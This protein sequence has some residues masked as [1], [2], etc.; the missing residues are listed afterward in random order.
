VAHAPNVEIG[1]GPRYLVHTPVFDGPFDLLL[2]LI[3]KEQVD[4]YEVS[5]SG[6]VD[7][8]LGELEH[9]GRM[10][11][12][13]AT[14]FLLIA[15]TLIE[16]KTRR[17]LPGRDDVDIDEE[18]WLLEERDLLLARLLE[19]KTFKDASAALVRLMAR[20]ERSLPRMAGLEERFL[21]VMPDLLEGVTPDDLRA[22]L[23]KA[24]TP[25]PSPKVDLDHVAPI[26]ISVRDAVEE[27]IGELPRLR[28]VTFRRLTGHLVDRLEVIVHF[29][30]VLEL[31]KQGTVELHQV[32]TFGELDIEWVGDSG[33]AVID[34][35]FISSMDTYDG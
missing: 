21:A 29:L 13:T 34:S 20:A 19:C 15:A 18:L 28:R 9:M 3:T 31:Y 30:A 4:L 35:G 16:L 17:L 24:V 22:A 10:D 25:K 8:Y 2:H 12:D 6:I 7:A 1:P 26:R 23:L 32:T 14:E 33:T 27:L 11:L 5:L